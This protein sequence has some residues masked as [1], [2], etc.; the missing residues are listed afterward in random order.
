MHDIISIKGGGSVA[1]NK[2]LNKV[3]C[4]KQHFPNLMRQKNFAKAAITVLK[5]SGRWRKR[6][7]N[8]I[9][10]QLLNTSLAQR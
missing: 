5:N 6:G 10:W 3:L 4:H 9:R 1:T 7:F 2:Q 8:V